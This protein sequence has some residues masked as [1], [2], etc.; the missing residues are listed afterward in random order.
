VIFDFDGGYLIPKGGKPE[1]LGFAFDIL[2]VARGTLP[3]GRFHPYKRFPKIPGPGTYSFL[4]HAIKIN[5]ALESLFK[6]GRLID[7]STSDTIPASNFVSGIFYGRG[8]VPHI[9]LSMTPAFANAYFMPGMPDIDDSEG[10]EAESARAGFVMGSLIRAAFA[11]KSVDHLLAKAVEG[12]DS[13]IDL[14]CKALYAQFRVGHPDS[15]FGLSTDTRASLIAKASEIFAEQFAAGGTGPFA[16]LAKTAFWKNHRQAAECLIDLFATSMKAVDA[17]FTSKMKNEHGEECA[18]TDPFG[19]YLR[20]E[21]LNNRLTP[22]I[23]LGVADE[24]RSFGTTGGV[25]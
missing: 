20:M 19:L 17:I 25:N 9:H 18:A 10:D 4:G 11:S 8:L 22:C 16:D 1:T 2:D 14:V 7:L 24:F 13:A 12:E 5:G 23:T 6:H 3:L 15:T 21:S